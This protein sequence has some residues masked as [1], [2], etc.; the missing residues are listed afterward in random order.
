MVIA[1]RTAPAAFAAVDV[2]VQAEHG[3]DGLAWLICWEPEVAGAVDAEVA[4]ITDQSD[5][6]EEIL[7]TLAVSGYA[8]I[9]DGPDQA[10]AVANLIAPEHLQ[11]MCAD[12]EAMADRVDNAGAIFVGPWSPAS[13]GDYVADPSHV[14]P[15]DGTARFSNVDRR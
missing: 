8:V 10:L 3:P 5:R 4:R 14:L 11:L 9:C 15:T 12:A 1:D 7:S 13:L 2:V 6:R